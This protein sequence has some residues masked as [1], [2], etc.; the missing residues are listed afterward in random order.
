M[1][2]ATNNK[3]HD[4]HAIIK[5]KNP[6]KKRLPARIQSSVHIF[7]S[8]LN[9]VETGKKNSKMSI[10]IRHTNK[11]YIILYSGISSPCPGSLQRVDDPAHPILEDVRNVTNRVGVRKQVPAAGTV[12]VVV[13][14]GAEDE[15]GRDGKEDTTRV[16]AWLY[17]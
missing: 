7:S 9:T 15:V 1:P 3:I 2:L 8:N 5:K 4:T 17:L 14:P 12:A 16:L 11:G 10:H 13:E 6:G